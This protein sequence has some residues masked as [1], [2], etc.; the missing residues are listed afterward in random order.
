MKSLHCICFC[1]LTIAMYFVSQNIGSS[2]STTFYTR[3]RNMKEMKMSS[4]N[5]HK[6][7]DDE[8]KQSKDQDGCSTAM[9]YEATANHL[10]DIVY[11]IDYHGV[12]THP[13]PTPK[14]PKP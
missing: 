13:T 10:E 2:A 11:H 4:P 9:E 8:A 3:R 1:L 6:V 14:H 12:T 7:I 5:C